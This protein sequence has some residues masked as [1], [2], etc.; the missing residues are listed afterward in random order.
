MLHGKAAEAK[1]RR[2]VAVAGGLAQVNRSHQPGEQEAPSAGRG[3]KA[4]PAGG[5]HRRTNLLHDNVSID[6]SYGAG[7]LALWNPQE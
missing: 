4:R 3:A 6:L 1:G 5:G 7:A 2:G